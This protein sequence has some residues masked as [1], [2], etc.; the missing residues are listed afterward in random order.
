MTVMVVR[1]IN[2]TVGE[3]MAKIEVVSFAENEDGSASVVFDMDKEA[4]ETFA[5]IGLLKVLTDE[6]NR[7]LDESQGVDDN[8]GC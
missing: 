6:A 1:F 5:K 7:V 8:V 3:N 2:A 4:L